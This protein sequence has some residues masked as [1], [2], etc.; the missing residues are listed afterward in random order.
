MSCILEF[1]NN[2]AASIQAIGSVCAILVAIGI[3]GHQTRVLRR[4]TAD[5]RHRAA[6]VLAVE[7]LPTIKAANDELVR[8]RE[9]NWNDPNHLEVPGLQETNISAPAGIE[10]A[11]NR[12]VALDENTSR[13]ILGMLAAT[14]E[15]C[16]LRLA[17]NLIEVPMPQL[18]GELLR[19]RDLL[20]SAQ[21]HSAEAEK[22]LR[23]IA[24]E[25]L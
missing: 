16:R 6:R 11:L 23:A 3:A 7:L 21:H 13:E 18:R 12:L 19:R 14:R 15:Y 4:D 22:H 9:L 5:A 25:K 24:A 20:D 17:T 8:A 2:N 10:D 1:L